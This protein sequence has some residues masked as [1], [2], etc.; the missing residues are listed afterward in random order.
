MATHVELTDRVGIL[1]GSI[2]I[3]GD[4]G[5][6]IR[7]GRGEGVAVDVERNSSVLTLRRS[8]HTLEPQSDADWERREE[9]GGGEI[10]E[11]EPGDARL[12]TGK[13]GEGVGLVDVV[14]VVVVAT[15]AHAPPRR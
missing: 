11:G 7:I 6:A 2:A 1:V 3:D 5:A 8:A 14:V 12:T 10:H 15:G 9:G 4:H 13:F